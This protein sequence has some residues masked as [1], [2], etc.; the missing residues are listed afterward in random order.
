MDVSQTKDKQNV[1]IHGEY[2]RATSCGGKKKVSNYTLAE[3]KTQCPLKNG[4]PILTL[5]EMLSQLKGMFDYYFV[6][7]KIYTP[8]DAESATLSAIQT[9][10]KLGMDDKVI[11]T[12]YDKTASYLLGSYSNIHAG[13]DTFNIKDVAKLPH[14]AHEYYMMPLSLIKAETPQ[15][16]ADM[17]KKLVVYTINTFEDLQKAYRQGI[18]MVMTDEVLMVQEAEAKLSLE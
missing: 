6:D 1:V 17:G 10:Q 18:R 9:V 3:L 4:Q 16:V 14:F 8:D 15:N 2:L 7:I 11:F 13:R 12:S 5:E